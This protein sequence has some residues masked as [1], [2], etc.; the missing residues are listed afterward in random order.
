M[1]FEIDMSEMKIA[2]DHLLKMLKSHKNVLKAIE[3]MTLLNTTTLYCPDDFGN[4]INPREVNSHSRSETQTND[5][6]STSTAAIPKRIRDFLFNFEVCWVE[7]D[8]YRPIR[9]VRQDLFFAGPNDITFATFVK[10]SKDL[11]IDKK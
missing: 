2:Y 3:A 11:K 8:N 10:V 6:Q 1:N 7:R 5:D 4:L 9:D